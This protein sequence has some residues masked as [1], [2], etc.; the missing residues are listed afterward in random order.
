M[1]FLDS[2]FHAMI[3]P[4]E[5][6]MMNKPDP[7]L[8]KVAGPCIKM[9]QPG[10]PIDHPATVFASEPQ[11]FIVDASQTGV[12]PMR[13]NI[14]V[15]QLLPWM[16]NNYYSF[17]HLHLTLT[18]YNLILTYSHAGNDEVQGNYLCVI[19]VDRETSVQLWNMI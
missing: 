11:Q 4:S 6:E 9:S 12:A 5:T 19:P 18:I 10:S 8:V 17:S 15:N 13:C 16:K 2:P 1:L 14:K 3:Y 7:A